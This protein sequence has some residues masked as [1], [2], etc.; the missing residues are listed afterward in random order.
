[1]KVAL[2]NAKLT[3]A[4]VICNPLSF[5]QVAA[6]LD[7]MQHDSIGRSKLLHK[8][9]SLDREFISMHHPILEDINNGPSF[10]IFNDNYFIFG[11]PVN[12]EPTQSNSDIKF[13]ISIRQRL[14]RGVLPFNTVALLTFTQKSLWKILESS[15]PFFDTN[16]NP[17]LTLGTPIFKDK[18]L[19]GMFRLSAEHESNGRDG[20]ESRSVNFLAADLNYFVSE[21]FLAEVRLWA[22]W[23]SSS[24][25]DLFSYRGY[26][27]AKMTY[28]SNNGNLWCSVKL[29]P[30]NRIGSFNTQVNLNYR[31]SDF[32]NQYLFI[33]FFDGYAENILDYN[34]YKMMVRAGICIKPHIRKFISAI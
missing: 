16:F 6:Q 2:K 32:F 24:N 12:K 9:R 10:G 25:P 4:V 26:G 22:G 34:Q 17:T 15:S 14:T 31:Y 5:T 21:K 19:R 7:S 8:I 11:C 29:Q 23:A 3:V 33:Q 18:Y 28:I 1:M 27:Y 20:D 13:Q 30:R